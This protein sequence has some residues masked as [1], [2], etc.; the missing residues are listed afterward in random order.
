MSTTNDEDG[1]AVSNSALN[2]LNILL[3]NSALSRRLRIGA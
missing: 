3:D 2:G 1:S